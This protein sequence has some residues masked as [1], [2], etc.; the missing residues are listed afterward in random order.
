MA[1]GREPVE[2]S[3]RAGKIGRRDLESGRTSDGESRMRGDGEETG[4]DDEGMDPSTGRAVP[5]TRDPT[6]CPKG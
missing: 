1:G 5:D 3:K 6:S 4:V 2:R